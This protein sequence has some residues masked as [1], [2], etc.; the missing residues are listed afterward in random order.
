M[1]AAGGRRHESRST[2]RVG[3]G[4]R[5]HRGHT[6]QK[7]GASLRPR[8]HGV[9]AV[10]QSSA[11]TGHG[12]QGSRP[13]PHRLSASLLSSRRLGWCGWGSSPRAGGSGDRWLMK[14]Q[15]QQSGESDVAQGG[16]EPH[17]G[18]DQI[19][20]GKWGRKIRLQRGILAVSKLNWR[21]KICLRDKF[22]S[23]NSPQSCFPPLLLAQKE[24][25][26]WNGGS[27]GW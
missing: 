1:S 4:L 27:E 12:A 17:Q 16:N 9:Q 2:G 3:T 14:L 20:L 23:Q 5:R 15:A 21:L 25:W 11:W 24:V 19:P 6:G 18:P 10:V 13:P 22:T 7:E 26:I 8:P